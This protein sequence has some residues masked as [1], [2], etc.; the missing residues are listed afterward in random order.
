ML[1]FV[2]A[3]GLTKQVTDWIARVSGPW[4]Y[5]LAFVLTF[6]ETGSLLFFVPGEFTLILAGIAAGAGGINIVALLAVG[7]VAALLGDATGFWIGRRWGRR[8]QESRLGRKLGPE[9]WVKAED[10]IT[11][12]KGV[13][14]LV[15]RGVGFLRAIMPATAGMT[16]MNYKQDFLP[17]DLV[18]A[19]TWSAAC[20]L[21]G[22]WLGD[23]AETIVQYIGWVAGGGAVVA[24][25]WILVKRRRAG[26][27]G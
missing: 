10:L 5:V 2:L 3:L 27:S 7:A 1:G 20:I 22:Y 21:G 19:L 17:F 14:V 18:G 12:R 9:N 11:R 15:G 4:L 16:G 13:V 25:L 8:L 24:V 6:A 26:R 23:R